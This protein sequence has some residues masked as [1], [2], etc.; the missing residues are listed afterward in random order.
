MVHGRVQGV[1]FRESL[2]IEAREHGV[3][4]WTRNRRDGTFEDYLRSKG[5]A[6]RSTRARARNS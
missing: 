2:R 3:S 5:Y 1:G 4:G 6:F